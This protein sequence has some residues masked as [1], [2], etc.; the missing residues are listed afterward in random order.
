MPRRRKKATIPGPDDAY[1]LHEAWRA[2]LSPA[3]QEALGQQIPVLV[4]HI[5]GAVAT[6][7][8]TAPA[9]TH[10]HVVEALLACLGLM[11]MHLITEAT[12]EREGGVDDHDERYP[13]L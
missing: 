5:L 11:E 4:H 9:T 10:H 6:H 1:A 2:A 7:K 12:R 13:G 3:D 8:A